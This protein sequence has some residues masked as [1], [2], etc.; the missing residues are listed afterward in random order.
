L[1]TLS[2]ATSL[3]QISM[4]LDGLAVAFS[5]NNTRIYLDV[6]FSCI[7]ADPTWESM[8]GNTYFISP[9]RQLEMQARC[10]ILAV[11]HT[12][13][14]RSRAKSSPVLPNSANRPFSSTTILSKSTIVF[15]LC[16]TAIIVWPLNSSRMSR[17]MN[18]SVCLSTLLVASSRKRTLFVNPTS[19]KFAQISWTFFNPAAIDSTSV[20][21]NVTAAESSITLE[22]SVSVLVRIR[23]TSEPP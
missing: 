11:V 23:D 6:W 1:Y 12:A 13:K 4:G 9:R 19:I 7:L 21:I 20:L 8:T 18:W 14:N 5:I 10:L 17:Y 16:A 3:Q 22:S 2:T 15:N